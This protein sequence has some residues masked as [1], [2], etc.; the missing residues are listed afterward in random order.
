M[1]YSLMIYQTPAQF[2]A[3]TDPAR[4]EANQAA[5]G[6]FVG[7]LQQAGVLV[8]TLGIEPSE[9]AAT[10]RPGNGSPHVKKGPY[11]DT[12]E[13]LGGLCVIEAPDLDAALAW[14][15]RAPFE[16]LGV[17][18]VRPTRVVPAN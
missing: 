11:A 9:T 7:A 3:R 6:S 10:V 2:A 8:T 12:K 15:K 1:Q 13:Q 18:E 16:H 5:F 17:I 14:A 4:R